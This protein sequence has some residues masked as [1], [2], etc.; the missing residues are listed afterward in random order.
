MHFDK[1]NVVIGMML[2]WF[3]SEVY[4]YMYMYTVDVDLC[5]VRINMAA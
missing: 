4:M 3:E 2:C 1:F 5:V